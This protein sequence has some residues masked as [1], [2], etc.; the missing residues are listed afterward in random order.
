MIGDYTS[1][2]TSSLKV[3][4]EDRQQM[5]LLIEKLCDIK[6]YR[7]ETLYLAVSLADTY[8]IGLAAN[9]ENAPS[10][11]KLAVTCLLMAAKLAQPF[12]PSFTRMVHILKEQGVTIEKQDFIDLEESILK[13]L[14]FSLQNVFSIDFLE[15]YLRLLGIN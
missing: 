5:V 6:Q 12:K 1:D 15:R 9:G 4:Q 10:L 3:T 8:L 14:D 2:L 13:V 7:R 11:S